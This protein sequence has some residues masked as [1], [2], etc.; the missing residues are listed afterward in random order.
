MS[1]PFL[2]LCVPTYERPQYLD[3]LLASAA[4][5]VER[6]PALATDLEIVVSDNASG[7]ATAAVVE[8][9]QRRLPRTLRP[10]R[11]ERNLGGPRNLLTSI[12]AATGEYVLFIGDDDRLRAGACE[13]IRE[14]IAEYASPP[15]C[16]F[17]PHWYLGHE[18]AALPTGFD[19]RLG[20][21]SALRGY[22]AV[23]GI[24]AGAA[25]RRDCAL[26]ALERAGV[27]R[28]LRTNW[29]HTALAFAAAALSG[30]TAPVA[31]RHGEIAYISEHHDDNVLYDAW[32]AWYTGVQGKVVAAQVLEE[33]LGRPCLRDAC[34][35]IFTYKRANAF[36]QK[37]TWHLIAIDGE[38]E[39]ADFIRKMEA[40]L[41][42][43]PEEFHGAPR[44]LLAIA[45]TPAKIRAAR[46]W[47]KGLFS[48]PLTSLLHPK[49]FARRLQGF[50][51][52]VLALLRYRRVHRGKHARY[53]AGTAK[54]IRFYAREGY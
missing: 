43:V 40:S 27:S 22:F 19:A 8:R 9:W 10:R 14:V 33:V 30:E 51:R 48:D 45:R 23:A 42:G 44:E 24:P 47:A 32:T 25:V 1:K 7:P 3:E 6:D 54:N 2:S 4:A 13:T 49:I 26:R 20:L 29:P 17:A 15:V 31:V 18:Y 50:R 38:E 21:A 52:S 5:E 37:A 53:L 36:V 35:D 41:G 46:Y 28:L 12:A 16:V 11:N 34:R 39:V